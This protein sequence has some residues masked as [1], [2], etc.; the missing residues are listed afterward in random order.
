MTT[1]RDDQNVLRHGNGTFATDPKGE[2]TPLG[3]TGI[4]RRTADEL[5]IHESI[6][7]APCAQQQ[8]YES[9]HSSFEPYRRAVDT[10]GYLAQAK[11]AGD[12]EA[13]ARFTIPRNTEDAMEISGEFFAESLPLLTPDEIAPYW[14]RASSAIESGDTF[15]LNRALLEAS[16]ANDDAHPVRLDPSWRLPGVRAEEGFYESARLVG[17]KLATLAD[18]NIAAINKLVRSDID[19]AK[20]AGWL[21]ANLEVSV[22]KSQGSM[23]M[24]VTS[25]PDELQTEPH[26]AGEMWV[27]QSKAAKEIES[28]LTQVAQQYGT[29]ENDT[30]QDF[31]S[32][33]FYVRVTFK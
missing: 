14:D 5:G 18:H 12:T 2:N 1:K 7:M 17:E 23:N 32:N 4:R 3:A 10:E 25:V 6:L 33:S 8:T 11:A 16:L 26:P 30:Q 27:R 21:P 29:F 22:R 24:L 19:E 9:L 28:R 15:E 31:F 20:K 13:I